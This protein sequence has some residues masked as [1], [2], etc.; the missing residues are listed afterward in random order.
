MLRIRIKPTIVRA[1]ILALL[2]IAQLFLIS[3]TLWSSSRASTILSASFT[4]ISFFVV[5]HI[6]KT[7]TDPS[8]KL[9]WCIMILLV[10]VSGG[11]FY[12]FFGLQ[13]SSKRLKLRLAKIEDNAKLYRKKQSGALSSLSGI[14]NNFGRQAAYLQNMEHY[15]VYASS[16]A[17]YFNSGEEK[18]ERLKTEL[19][20]A[21][22]F[23][24]LEY[25]IIEE[26]LMWNSI[27]DILAEKARAGLDVRVLYDGI[28]CL[29]TLPPDYPKKLRS[30]GIKCAVF[31]PA[32]A[33]PSTLLNHRDHRKIL[34]IDGKAAFTGGVNLADEYINIIDK[35][36]HW[37]DAAI[38]ISGE[39]V[40]SLTSMFLT[41]WQLQTRQEE[42]C[43][44]FFPL[45][46]DMEGQDGYIQPYA[47]NPLDNENVGASVYLNI[48]NAAKKYVFITTPYLIVDH[49]MMLALCLAAKSGVDVRIITPRH[50]DKRYVHRATRSYYDELVEAGV[51]VY[52]Y[53]DGFMHAKTFVSD[54]VLASVGTT[55]MDFRS[56]YLHYECGALIYSG[57]A[58][59]AVKDDFE[60]TLLRCELIKPG[61]YKAKTAVGR[62]INQILRL[63]APLL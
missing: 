53:A 31:N 51:K 9:I 55:N 45:C 11:I 56:L 5:L 24:F 4:I 44:G 21:E 60:Q 39:A 16:R 2:I 17:L 48:I 19:A 8:Y 15:P 30:L 54:D 6:V 52:E 38:F 7:R 20:K 33:F 43:S 25:F 50:W 3:Y 57:S 35:Y 40:H 46:K 12:L 61:Q 58:V 41:M 29:L 37:K 62:I 47:D 42:E 18:F 32:R 36:G 26:G 10:P 28:G 14:N 22:N 34:I 1:M 59:M 63:L 49:A 23:I 13:P 27:L